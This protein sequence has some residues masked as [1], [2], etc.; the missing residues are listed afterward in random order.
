ME[1]TDQDRLKAF[2]AS[3]FLK[4]QKELADDESL[5]GAG[6]IDSLGMLEL[7]G[8]IERTFRISVNPSEVIIEHFDTVHRILQ[9]IAQKKL[10]PL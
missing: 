10:Q 2:I 9:F 3:R 7:V 1:K 6:I 8:F 4:D 5:F